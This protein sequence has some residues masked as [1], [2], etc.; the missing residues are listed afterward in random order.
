MEVPLVFVK[1]S[2]TK[3]LAFWDFL[4]VFFSSFLSEI[5][6]PLSPLFQASSILVLLPKVPPQCGPLLEGCP[7]WSVKKSSKG[8]HNF[9]PFSPSYYGLHAV[10]HYEAQNSSRFSCH[11]IDPTP[12][13]FP[14]N[15]YQ[16]FLSFLALRSSGY[17][18][19]SF[20]F[21]LCRC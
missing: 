17:T 18:V 11:H 20:C 8:L 19:P 6:F 16:L 9:N 7:G 10:T 12:P 1:H 5:S 3:W 2:K 15:T 21:F 14:V 13:C 4:T